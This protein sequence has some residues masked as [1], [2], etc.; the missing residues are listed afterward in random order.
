MATLGELKARIADE[1]TRPDLAAQ[2]A[3]AVTSAIRFYQRR[4][5]S[6]MDGRSVVFTSADTEFYTLDD[7]RQVDSVQAQDGSRPLRRVSPEWIETMQTGNAVG[8]PTDWSWFGGGLRFYPRPDGVYPLVI[9]GQAIEEVPTA[10]DYAGAW[11]NEAEALIR[12]RAKADLLANVIR[13]NPEELSLARA[14]E[15]EELT[16]LLADRARVSTGTVRAHYL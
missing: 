5:F 8:Q 9:Y 16:A 13:E 10:D 11:V 15:A 6:F 2:I 7:I 14:Q 4:R 1:L 12:F 3:L